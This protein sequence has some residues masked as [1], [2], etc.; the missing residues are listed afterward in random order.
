MIS[1]KNIGINELRGV[2]GNREIDSRHLDR[3][4][5][6]IKHRNL[7]QIC[8]IRVNSR[9]EIIDGQHRVEAARKL[10]LEK[11][12]C[13][14]IEH[15]SL[16]DALVINQNNKNWSLMDWA[17]SH[18]KLGNKHYQFFIDFVERYK[19]G[20]TLSIQIVSVG[21]SSSDGYSNCG[22]GLNSFRAGAFKIT[23]PNKI[24]ETVNMI[25]EIKDHVDEKVYKHRGFLSALIICFNTK[26]YSQERMVHKLEYQQIKRCSLM[27]EYIEQLEKI[28]NH[29]ATKG[30][31]ITFGDKN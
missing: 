12:P 8:P 23:S 25:I 17:N 21:S 14:V 11:L 31:L 26:G 2:K 22:K 16:D 1:I 28:Y 3:L 13:M 18:A 9:Y 10:G 15:A 4:V 29:A 30:T 5:S 27:S 7:L 6:S 19:F 24:D 20:P